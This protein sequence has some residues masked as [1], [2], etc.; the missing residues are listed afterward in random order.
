MCMWTCENNRLWQV[1]YIGEAQG[2]CE[3]LA[4]QQATR[5]MTEVIALSMCTMHARKRRITWFQHLNLQTLRADNL[6]VPAWLRVAVRP[7]L[8]LPPVLLALIDMRY[9]MRDAGWWGRIKCK[10]SF[11]LIC[12]VQHAVR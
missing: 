10:V 8:I 9:Q 11:V 4:G 6:D 5:I 12:C 7:V 2:E 1:Q 3:S